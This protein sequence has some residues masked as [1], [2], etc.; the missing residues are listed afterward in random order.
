[1]TAPVRLQRSRAKGS[2]L[3]SPNGLPCV[4]VGRP[5]KWGNP[6]VLRQE[7]RFVSVGVEW[8][9]DYPDLIRA[10]SGRL[11]MYPSKGA[12]A[13][14]AIR[15]HAKALSVGLLKVS[16]ADI[17]RELAGK[18]LVCWCPIGS[19]CHADVLLRVANGGEP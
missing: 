9:D 13:G 17:R 12:A 7:Q 6:F 1:M 18:N 11:F 16:V 3:V 2:H 15:F 10:C 5:S 8:S 14:A 4:Y 19:P